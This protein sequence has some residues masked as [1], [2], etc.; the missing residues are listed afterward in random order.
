MYWLNKAVWFF[1]NP[2]GVPLFTPIVAFLVWRLS[3]NRLVRK[4]AIVIGCIALLF[5]W[6]MSTPLGV[7]ILGCSLE[8]PY[9]SM[10]MADTAPKADA[11][12]LLGGGMAKPYGE[13]SYPDMSLSADRVW[14]AVR[15]YKAGKAPVIITTG[16]SDD[17]STLPLLLDFGVPKSA[18]LIDVESRNTYENSR[19]TEK[20]LLSSGKKN[21]KV[22]LVTSAWHMRRASSNFSKTSLEVIPAPTDFA[23]YTSRPLEEWWMA[24]SPSPYTFW[25]NSIFY[26]EHLGM[27]ARR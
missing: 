19:F 7:H 23:A 16:T 22:L 9:L 13:I 26:K 8:K 14:H 1:L 11:I 6:F 27:L 18:I 17:S 15:L 5:L 20:M 21:P 12:V 4:M 2:A 3:K 24:L 25:L 10:Q